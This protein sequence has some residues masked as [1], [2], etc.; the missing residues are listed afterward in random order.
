MT[1]TLLSRRAAPT[2][3]RDAL[4]LDEPIPTPTGWTTLGALR[5]G[6]EL[7]S[8]DGRVCRVIAVGAVDP[9]PDARVIRFS[10]GTTIDRPAEHPWSTVDGSDSHAPGRAVALAGPLTLPKLA[11]PIPPY[12]L[13]AWLGDG[14]TEG[15]RLTLNRED[16]DEIEATIRSE[17][18]G[19]HR[20]PS[21]ERGRSVRIRVEGLQVFLRRSLILGCK[22]IPPAYLRG[23]VAQR[24]ALLAG[25]MDTDGSSCATAGHRSSRCELTLTRKQLIA[26][27]VELIRTLGIA[28]NSAEYDAVLEGR[29]VGRRWRMHFQANANLFTVTRKAQRWAPLRTDRTR[30]RYIVDVRRSEPSPMRAIMVDSPDDTFLCGRRMVP[31]HGG[32][33]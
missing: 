16:A 10:D 20:N 28:V 13:G 1:T 25:L 18:F 17:G 2:T 24:R 27:V 33:A 9:Y 26:P 5:P 7:F 31:T 14:D 3:V 19:T 23:S 21:G 29:V 12:T 30:S 6:D 11:L 8:G 4:R 32:T 22:D 15:A